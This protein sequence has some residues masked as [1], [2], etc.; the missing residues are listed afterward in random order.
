[1][2]VPLISGGEV[3]GGLALRSK[4]IGEYTD[5]DLRLAEGI[6]NQIAGAI[7]NAQLYR[8][9]RRVEK[10]REKLIK[11]LQEALA[12]VKQLSGM[13]PIC[14]SCKKIRDDRGYWNQIEV[15]VRDHSEAEFTHGMC[16]ECMKKLYPDFCK[17]EGN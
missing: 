9:Q 5:W 6:G 8:E 11:D 4:G 16:P 2:T 10:E 15:Y 14:S 1:M 17:D 12:R 13:L 7:T 3:I